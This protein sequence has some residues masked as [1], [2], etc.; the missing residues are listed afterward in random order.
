MG[1]EF[2]D[3]YAVQSMHAYRSQRRATAIRRE[4]GILLQYKLELVQSIRE[5]AEWRTW[6]HARQPYDEA[7]VQTRQK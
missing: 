2:Q 7:A 1:V 6:R 3:V 4:D 5:L